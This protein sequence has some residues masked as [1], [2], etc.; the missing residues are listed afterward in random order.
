M[1]QNRD[2][3]TPTKLE[4]A[5]AHIIATTITTLFR[6][7]EAILRAIYNLLAGPILRRLGQYPGLHV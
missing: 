5:A 3:H 2:R 6:I 1:S 4:K 7:L